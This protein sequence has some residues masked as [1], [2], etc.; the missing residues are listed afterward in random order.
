MT[1]IKIGDKVIMNDKY[2]V[3][4]IHRGRIWTVCS[5]PWYCCGT[6]IVKLEG[7]SGGYA[8]DGLDLVD[9][10]EE[11]KM[12][13]TKLKPCLFCKSAPPRKSRIAAE[14]CLFCGRMIT[15][16]EKSNG[17]YCFT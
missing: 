12:S 4:E 5:E 11:E 2:L 13:K 7:W 15:V 8:V 14:R 10:S 6:L 9:E 3:S 1:D 17:K 16:K